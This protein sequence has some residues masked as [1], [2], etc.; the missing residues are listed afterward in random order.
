[1][2][3]GSGPVRV[4][5]RMRWGNSSSVEA[6]DWVNLTIEADNP[7]TARAWERAFGEVRQRAMDENV[8]LV[9]ARVAEREYGLAHYRTEGRQEGIPQRVSGELHGDD[10]QRGVPDGV[11]SMRQHCGEEGVSEIIGVMLLIGVTVLAVAVV[12]A[13]FLSGPQPD[14]IPHATIVAGNESGSLAL[15]HE[16]GDP[17]RKGEYRIY[18]DTGSGLVDGTGDFQRT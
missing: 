3:A 18:V 8:D 10:P 4:E 15:V 6:Y 5:T 11:N 14:E 2:I 9:V 12:A 1:M 13:V 7:M 16:G 17:L